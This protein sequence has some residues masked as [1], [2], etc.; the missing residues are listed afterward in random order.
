[1]SQT[2]RLSR[3]DV[4]RLAAVTA[5]GAL[6]AACAP[7]ATE[8]IPESDGQ[9]TA[10]EAATVTVA[11]PTEEPTATKAPAP[12]TTPTQIWYVWP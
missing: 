8:I 11:P 1:M 2:K 9:P 10:E 12:T 7:Q 4:L 5:T 3:R 6:M